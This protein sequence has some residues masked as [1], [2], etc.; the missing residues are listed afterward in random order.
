VDFAAL[1]IE[2]AKREINELHVEAGY[3]LN[4]SLLAAG[5]IDELLLYMAPTLLGNASM[6]MFDL[7]MF[8]A[9]DQTIPLTIQQLDFVGKDIRIRARFSS[10]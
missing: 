6:G 8:T 2:L 4:G 9:M 3:K 10:H 5:E 7:P 1:M